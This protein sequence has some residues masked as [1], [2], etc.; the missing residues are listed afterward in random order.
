VRDIQHP[1]LDVVRSSAEPD[2]G[3]GVFATALDRPLPARVRQPA[4]D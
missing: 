1:E 4:G 3:A 2:P